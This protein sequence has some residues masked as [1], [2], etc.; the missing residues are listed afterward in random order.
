[1]RTDFFF[2]SNMRMSL[3]LGCTISSHHNINICK[4][5]IEEGGFI[6]RVMHQLTV[7]LVRSVTADTHED[8]NS[9]MIITP[10][11]NTNI[12]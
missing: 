1:M 11:V 3:D 7:Y 4:I 2:F 9:T 5:Q 8:V 12:E 10:I 6:A